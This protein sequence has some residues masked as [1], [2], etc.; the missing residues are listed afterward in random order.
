MLGSRKGDPVGLMPSLVRRFLHGPEQYHDVAVP[1]L[2]HIY[3]RFSWD[4]CSLSCPKS[5]Q[6]RRVKQIKR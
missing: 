6:T 1:D 3:W 5:E 4:N 2:D